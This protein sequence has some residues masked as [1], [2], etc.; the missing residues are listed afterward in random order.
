MRLYTVEEVFVIITKYL[1]IPFFT[2]YHY[3]K[4]SVNPSNTDAN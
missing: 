4:D 2:V 3:I 1:I